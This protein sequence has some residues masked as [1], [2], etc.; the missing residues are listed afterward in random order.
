MYVDIAIKRVNDLPLSQWLMPQHS[1][2]SVVPLI[3]GEG[4][5]FE[6]HNHNSP[7]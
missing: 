5:I 1:E 2:E 6:L 4:H 7:K 3:Q